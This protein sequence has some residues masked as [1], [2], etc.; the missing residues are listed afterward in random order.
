MN[1][2][3]DR[4][5]MADAAALACILAVYAAVGILFTALRKEAEARGAALRPAGSSA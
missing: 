5:Y 2:A 4:F 1:E 3:A